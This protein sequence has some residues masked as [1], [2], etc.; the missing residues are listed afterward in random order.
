M[1]SCSYR[2]TGRARPDQRSDP[3]GGWQR[4]ARPEQLAPRAR[5]RAA[6]RCPDA[7][8]RSLP[9]RSARGRGRGFRYGTSGRRG[10]KARSRGCE[11]QTASDAVPR[12]VPGSGQPLPGSKGNVP[13]W[14]SRT[15]PRAAP[16]QSRAARGCC[17]CLGARTVS[18]A[19]PSLL[20]CS[21]GKAPAGSGAWSGTA[22]ARRGPSACPPA[23]RAGAP[24][25]LP[26]LRDPPATAASRAPGGSGTGPRRTAE[27]RPPN[28]ES[29]RGD[30][31][32][33][34]HTACGAWQG[35]AGTTGGRN[36]PR[37]P[38]DGGTPRRQNKPHGE[39]GTEL[40]CKRGA[41]PSST[42]RRA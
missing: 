18:H 41:P 39:G 14:K 28:P 5:G 37:V 17:P 38:R 25:C 15:A 10:R 20:P 9:G 29:L 33:R 23:R 35:G 2:H 19:C 22:R 8:P 36:R 31:A 13:P 1:C 3:R 40:C 16:Q 6:E 26:G 21:L 12:G 11:L 24:Q 27:L 32:P 42:P 7:D 30:P 4:G 34:S